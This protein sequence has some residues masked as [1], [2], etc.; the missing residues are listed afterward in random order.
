MSIL[1]GFEALGSETWLA[2]GAKRTEHPRVVPFHSSPHLDYSRHAD[3]AAREALDRRRRIDRRLGLEDYNHPYTHY[4]LELTGAPPD[5]VLCNNLHGGFFDLRFL[6]RLSRRVP[7]VLRLSDCWTF[8]GHCA[9]P[10]GCGRWET[11]CG[12]C[13]DLTIP[14][15]IDRDATATN[16][17]RKRAILG[18]SRLFLVTPS[19]WLM[20]RARRSLLAPAIEDSAVVANGVDLDIF[21]PGSRLETRRRLALDPQ[22]TILLSV[23]NLGARNPY[24]DFATLRAAFQ[25]VARECSMRPLELVV[26]GDEG[27]PEQLSDD[28]RIRHLPYCE[29]S[30]RLA[31]LYRAADVLAHATHEET[32]GLTAA[33]AMACGTPVVVAGTGGIREV[34]DHGHTGLLVP[35]RTP[36]ELAAA[37]GRLVVDGALRERMGAAG[38]RAARARF[39][40][41]RMVRELHAWCAGVAG[42]WY[43]SVGGRSPDVHVL[44][45]SIR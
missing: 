17:R 13:P 12:S 23:S 18:A 8:T 9:S 10:M 40:Q 45:G 26:V 34:V 1:D 28:A 37:L 42:R 36:A 14:P 15:A 35:P 4:L 29:S 20:Q 39:D 24:K 19:G 27:P 41:R 33:E 2:V 25:R 44:A 3:P 21:A 30:A 43:G 7:V 32:F 5:L 16:W 6:S 11:G 38:V 22:A 31:D